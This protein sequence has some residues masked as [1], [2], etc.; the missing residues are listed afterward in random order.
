MAVWAAVS[1]PEK[2]NFYLTGSADLTIKYWN[3]D[4]VLNTFS[5]HEDVVRC[6]VV[7]ST[8]IFISASND[9]TVRVWN[10]DSTQ[11]MQKYNSLACEFIFSMTLMNQQSS[12]QM[13]LAN[14]GESGFIEICSIDCKSQ[15]AHKQFIRTPAQSA[16]SIA[17][18]QEVVKIK[19]SLG[20]GE[21]DMELRYK[22]GS[23]PMDAAETFV[24]E[25]SIPISYVDEI[26][27]YI[28]TNIPEAR[29]ATKK[30]MAQMTANQRVLVDG[31]VWDYVFDVATEDGRT[32]QLPYNVGEDTNW[33]ARRFVEK[34]N[35]PN[36]FV[37]K[38]STL[39]HLQVPELSASASSK[40]GFVDPFT[41]TGRY[42]PGMNSSSSNQMDSVSDPFIG[43]SR[44]IPAAQNGTL[45]ALEAVLSN[46]SFSS[47]NDLISAID[48]GLSWNNV[49]ICAVVVWNGF[50]D[51]IVPILDVL[52]LALLNEQFNEV[53]CSI[54][55][56][57]PNESHAIKTLQKYNTLLVSIID[58][59]LQLACVSAIANCS[60]LLLA[61]SLS[62]ASSA[63]N[64]RE[65]MAN[66]LIKVAKE[67]DVIALVSR[68]KDAVSD[69]N[70]KAIAR[71]IIV[72]TYAL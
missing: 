65:T 33:A 68:L 71:D 64:D 52:R 1:I 38:V 8:N 12:E 13:M 45:S 69:E 42:V 57:N 10:L 62:N 59:L 3:G 32:L 24:K 23:D 56:T 35:L 72:M 41:G 60:L 36:Q 70:G 21:P 16:W 46:S 67:C 44:Y 7:V 4:T 29:M 37:D 18:Q 54:N 61:N 28:K 43:G 15:I 48:A 50:A 58:S 2:P 25:N 17:V 26:C 27:E 6:V 11:C 66:A 9:F 53:Y 51:T 31:Q 55:E 63:K 39:L 49:L 30:K 22:K 40:P 20:E 47:N 14:C 19:I 5:G 34:N